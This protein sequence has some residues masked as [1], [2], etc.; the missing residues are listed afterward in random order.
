VAFAEQQKHKTASRRFRARSA[1]LIVF[2][3][4]QMGNV[5]AISPN[6]ASWR[7]EVSD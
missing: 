4:A 3:I 2:F 7:D 1:R 6:S 5:R